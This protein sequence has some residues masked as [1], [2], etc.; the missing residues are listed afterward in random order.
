[1][2]LRPLVD[3]VDFRVH[4]RSRTEIVRLV[5][6]GAVA[7]PCPSCEAATLPRPYPTLV[8]NGCGQRGLLVWVEAGVTTVVVATRTILDGQPR[9]TEGA[10]CFP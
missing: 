9:A 8:S 4:E 2:P 7:T 5:E 10:G 3:W 1:M 6:T